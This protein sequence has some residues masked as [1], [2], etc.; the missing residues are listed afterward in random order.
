MVQS[1]RYIEDIKRDKRLSMRM[2]N[3]YQLI[4]ADTNKIILEGPVSELSKFGHSADAISNA[5][6]KK[7]LY[8]GK[9]RVVISG[10][11]AKKCDILFQ[12]TPEE[13]E[14]K[15]KKPVS[16][17]KIIA[18]ISKKA[19]DQN[20]SYGQYQAKQRKIKTTFDAN[21]GCWKQIEI[22]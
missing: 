2:V 9:Y 10:K 5:A 11:V 7:C 12:K 21:L 3:N 20:L 1:R 16:N 4:E 17:T 13:K 19:A 14:T 8:L 18:E 22:G 15:R 6:N